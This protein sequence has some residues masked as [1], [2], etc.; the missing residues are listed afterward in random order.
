MF[1]ICPACMVKLKEVNKNM[2]PFIMKRIISI[3]SFILLYHG[4]HNFTVRTMLPINLSLIILGHQ[5]KM[6]IFLEVKSNIQL[7]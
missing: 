3:N 5:E 7:K 1:N 2:I 6:L 4:H